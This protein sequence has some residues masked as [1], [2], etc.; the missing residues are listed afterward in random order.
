MHVDFEWK[1]YYKH[2]K[3]GNV[4]FKTPKYTNMDDFIHSNVYI[5]GI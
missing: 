1:S 5:I 2:K 3:D 4:N